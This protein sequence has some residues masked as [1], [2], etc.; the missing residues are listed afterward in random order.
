MKNEATFWDRAAA[1]YVASPIKDMNA[2]QATM[3]R[4]RSYLKSTD[5]ALELGCGSGN[6]AIL[7]APHVAKMTGS[8]ISSEMMRHGQERVRSEGIENVDFLHA[9]VMDDSVP[10]GAYDVVMAFNLLHLCPDLPGTLSW[11][12]DR[13]KPGGLLISKTG[14]LGNRMNWLRPVIWAMQV[15]GKAPYVNF[16]TTDKLDQ[17]IVDAGFT[18]IETGGYPA[19]LPNHFVV[20]RRD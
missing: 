2:Y 3:D 7:L 19:K 4:T 20:A 17:H 5:H 16:L 6:T 13:L 18:I 10:E 14:C 1:K 12:H 9:P 8:D 15:V 11:A